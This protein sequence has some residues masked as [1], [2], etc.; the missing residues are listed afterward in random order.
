MGS[1]GGGGEEMGCTGSRREISV[2]RRDEFNSRWIGSSIPTVN[3]L[4]TNLIDFP[5]YESVGI[6]NKMQSCNRI[7][8]S[9]IY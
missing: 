9:K 8:Y 2:P 7:Y 6:T 1:K 4:K 5:K 3:K